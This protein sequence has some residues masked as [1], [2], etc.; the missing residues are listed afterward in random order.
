[1]TTDMRNVPVAD[2]EELIAMATFNPLTQPVCLSAPLR[3]TPLTAWQEHIPFAMYLVAALRP[4]LLMEQG[5]ERDGAEAVGALTEHV[6][7]GEQG[8]KAAAVH[9]LR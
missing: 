3:L 1:M 4:R 7:T 5:R 9:C 2:R 6:T 8:Q